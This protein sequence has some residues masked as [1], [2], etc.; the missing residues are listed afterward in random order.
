MLQKN[1]FHVAM[2]ATLIG[3]TLGFM[4]SAQAQIK[5]VNVQV[6]GLSCPFCVKGVEKH[7]KKVEGVKD[8]STSLKKGMVKLHYKPGAP[9]DAE[10]LRKAV[11]RGG[12]TPG[13]VELSATGKVARTGEDFLFTVPGTPASFVLLA[14]T[15]AGTH[16]AG[17]G[18][19]KKNEVDLEQ[20]ITSDKP[21][22]I[23]GKVHSHKNAK[24]GLSIERVETATGDE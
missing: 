2:L 21:M 18:V 9:F 14:P 23:L 16:E 3:L 15:T 6:K 12:F 4:S 17:E 11:V 22:Q 19:T 10:S 13:D 8:I 20:A 7:L 1:R 5:E 24:P